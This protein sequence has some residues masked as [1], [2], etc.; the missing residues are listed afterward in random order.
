MRQQLSLAARPDADDI[1]QNGPPPLLLPSPA[2]TGDG[3]SVRFVANVLQEVHG[4]A[5]RRQNELAMPG[6]EYGLEA[7]LAGRS[8]G[9]PEQRDV[10]HLQLIQHF[11]GAAKLT[12][13]AIDDDRVRQ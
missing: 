4:A 9:N 6:K 12:D 1:V 8:L 2:V 5:V 7:R 11:I 13:S 3:E 10:F